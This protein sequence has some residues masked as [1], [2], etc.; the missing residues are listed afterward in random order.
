MRSRASA[1]CASLPRT[2]AAVKDRFIAEAMR[3]AIEGGRPVELRRLLAGIRVLVVDGDASSRERMAKVLGVAGA[4]TKTA[5][6][7]AEPLGACVPTSS[8]PT[9]ASPAATCW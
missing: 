5:A 6:R 4:E 3:E 1:S 7:A 2:Q 8:F 9:S